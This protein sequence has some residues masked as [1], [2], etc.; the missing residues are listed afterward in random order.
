M[1]RL[2]NSFMRKC[3]LDYWVSFGTGLARFDMP[4]CGVEI[5]RDTFYTV[6]TEFRRIYVGGVEWES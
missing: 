3:T 2:M 1:E 5:E 6:R 4:V